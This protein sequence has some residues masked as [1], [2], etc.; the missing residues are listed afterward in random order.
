MTNQA[1]S[2]HRLH[3]YDLHMRIER[4]N[5]QIRMQMGLAVT[6]FAAVVWVNAYKLA[7]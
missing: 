6:S 5:L 4:T 2:S 1:L 7:W 3:G